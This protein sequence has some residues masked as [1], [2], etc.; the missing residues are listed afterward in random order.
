MKDAEKKATAL[1]KDAEQRLAQ[2]RVEREAVAGYIANLRGV[3]DSAERVSAEHDFPTSAP[4]EPIAPEAT[5]Q[6][7]GAD[8][9]DQEDDGIDEQTREREHAS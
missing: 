4:D 2:I 7:D 5:S 3:L 8:D 9:T 1:M 6:I